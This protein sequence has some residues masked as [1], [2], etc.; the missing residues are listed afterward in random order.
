MSDALAAWSALV[1]TAL[2]GTSRLAAAPA[3]L[4]DELAAV[5]SAAA[6][7]GAAES[8]LLRQAGLLS[9]FLRAGHLAPRSAGPDAPPPVD[10][11]TPCGPHA[12]DA[13][14]L[15]LAGEH[16]ALLPEWCEAAARAGRCVPAHLLPQFLDRMARSDPA[17]RPA[18]LAA[19]LGPR[20]C[21]L[22][23][24]DPTWAGLLEVADEAVRETWDTGARP[25]RVALLH[26]LRRRDPGAGRALLEST[27]EREAP[28]DAAALVACLATG[29]SLA[30]HDLLESLLDAK[31]KA[32]RQAAARLLGALPGSALAQRMIAR[33]GPLL[34]Y[35]PAE[36]GVL[37]R[38]RARLEVVAPGSEDAKALARDGVDTGRKRGSLGPKAATLAHMLASTPLAHWSAQWGATPEEIVAAAVGSDW[39]DALVLGWIEACARQADA[40]WARALL[41]RL[42]AASDALLPLLDP[43][44]V[45]ALVEALPPPAREAFVQEVL[46]ADPR[47][48][49]ARV[50]QLALA[51]CRHAWSEAFTEQVLDVVRRHFLA[52]ERAALR[53]LLPSLAARFSPAVAGRLASGWPTESPGW[54]PADRSLLDQLVAVTELRRRYLQELAP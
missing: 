21:W 39:H 32:V 47:R 48:I 18:A 12:G 42:L 30:D 43:G 46:E 7:N 34:A 52:P 38:R 49:H 5:A 6:G 27:R 19:L 50:A 16:E 2:M 45:P 41:E 35:V 8:T 28:E 29:L 24:L 22:A 14:A 40:R 33:V 31:H 10:A 13:L 51:A 17:D 3:T 37:K 36:R 53:A 11:G 9:P 26:R 23:G 15:L 20:G 1:R 4:P 44:A 25:Q 54:Q